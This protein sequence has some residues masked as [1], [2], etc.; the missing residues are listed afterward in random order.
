MTAQVEIL[1]DRKL[2][3]VLTV[4]VQAVLQFNGKDH[5]TKKVDD[6]F[7]QTEVELGVSNEKFVEV[8]KG[9]TE[10]DVVAMNPISLMTEE[11]KREAFG[12]APR[13]PRRTGAKEATA[14]AAAQAGAAGAVAPGGCCRASRRQGGRRRPRA[15]RDG[16]GRRGKAGARAAVF[17]PGWPS[18]QPRKTDPVVQRAPTKKRQSSTRKAGLTDDRPRIDAQMAERMKNFGGGGGGWRWRRLAAAVSAAAAAAGPAA[19]PGGSDQ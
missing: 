5:V 1:V 3:N 17:R 14:E 18:S 19:A 6:R 10:G 12:S 7:V 9:S 13:E 16:Q 2:D 11:E 8:T 4:P 15:R